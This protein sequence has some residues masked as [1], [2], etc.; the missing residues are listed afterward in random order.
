MSDQ[1]WISPADLAVRWNLS[2]ENIRRNIRSGRLE[3]QK[4]PGARKWLVSMHS[5][6]AIE[7]PFHPSKFEE[8]RS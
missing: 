2:V 8:L 1:P 3:A 5:V 4:L 7:R 6:H